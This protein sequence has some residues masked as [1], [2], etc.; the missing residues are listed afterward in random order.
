M[1]LKHTVKKTGAWAD[2]TLSDLKTEQRK[3]CGEL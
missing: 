2:Y 1:F 3:V